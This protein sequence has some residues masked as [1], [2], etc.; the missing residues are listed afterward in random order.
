MYLFPLLMSQLFQ[1]T[2]SD[3]NEVPYQVIELKDEFNIV[4]PALGCDMSELSVEI[5]DNVLSITAPQPQLS[6]PENSKVIWQEFVMNEMNYQFKLPNNVLIDGIKAMLKNGNL[7][8]TLP[9]KEPKS[10]TIKVDVA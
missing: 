10:H 4:V 2:R 6:L 3:R 1:D 7:N 5:N 8:I 9:K